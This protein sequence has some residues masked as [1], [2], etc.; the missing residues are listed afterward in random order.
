MISRR[1]II[2]FVTNQVGGVH[3]DD[4]FPNVKKNRDDAEKLAAEL[5]DK[6]SADWRNGLLYELLSIGFYLGRS[7]DLKKLSAAIQE[8]S[9]QP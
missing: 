6:V 7:E 1:T 9:R 8:T 3:A 4:L 2:Q 5:Y